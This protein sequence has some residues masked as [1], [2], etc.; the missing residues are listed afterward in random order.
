VDQIAMRKFTERYLRATNC[1]IIESAPSFLHTQLS[2][3]A[4]KDLVNRPFFWMYV[5][6]MNLPANPV[7]LCFVFD[8]ENP[9]EG[10]RAEHLFYGSPRFRQLLQSAQNQGK[11]VRLYQEPARWSHFSSLSKGYSPW[12]GVHYL[13]SYVC[14]QKMDRIVSLGINLQTGEIKKD[15]DDVLQK[16]KWSHKLPERRY[17]L[18]PRMSIQEAVGELEYILTE[19]LTEEDHQWAEDADQRLQDE[20]NQVAAFFPVKE[21]LTDEQSAA[22]TARERECIWQYHPRIEVNLIAAGLFY[23]EVIS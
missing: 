3:E 9:P 14:D 5:E 16:F 1:H 12:I 17:T 18:N 20:L 23:L 10:K 7:Q 6:K 21:K 22:K 13:I 4:D 2:V 8:P 11:F 19:E 15:F